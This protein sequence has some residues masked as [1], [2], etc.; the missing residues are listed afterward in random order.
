MD[1]WVF[2][3]RQLKI[4]LDDLPAGTDVS[5]VREYLDNNEL[6]LACDELCRVGTAHNVVDCYFWRSLALAANSMLE[7]DCE[8]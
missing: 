7:G 4:A 8:I 5:Q 1:K 2:I 6:G 3:G